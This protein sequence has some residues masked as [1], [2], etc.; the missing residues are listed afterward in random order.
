MAAT[1]MW[2]RRLCLRADSR[3][4]L[5]SRVPVLEDAQGLGAARVTR[6]KR[7]YVDGHPVNEYVPRA[8][9]IVLGGGLARRAARVAAPAHPGSRSNGESA[10]RQEWCELGARAG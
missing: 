9:V 2:L 4:K 10:E 3:I 7:R 6:R 5:L 8:G 1:S